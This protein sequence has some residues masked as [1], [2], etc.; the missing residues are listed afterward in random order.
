MWSRSSSLPTAYSRYWAP[1]S[2][3]LPKTGGAFVSS[4]SYRIRPYVV[5][6][7]G[8]ITRCPFYCMHRMRCESTWL[9][10][11]LFS[12]LTGTNEYHM[13]ISTHYS[14]I[15]IF[16]VKSCYCKAK[17]SQVYPLELGL[18]LL[19]CYKFFSHPV[20]CWML[21]SLILWTHRSSTGQHELQLSLQPLFLPRCV[22][23]VLLHLFTILSNWYNNTGY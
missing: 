11:K 14:E 18:A 2:P 21:F 8:K 9:L 16:K 15:S 6:Y 19:L 1:F 10:Y 22:H 3:A 23:S 13:F 17:H 20:F 5:N 7:S 12:S 4:R